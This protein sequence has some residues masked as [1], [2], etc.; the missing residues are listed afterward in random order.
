VSSITEPR[1]AREII[2]S[3]VNPPPEII[4]ENSTKKNKND[5]VEI[6]KDVSEK[7]FELLESLFNS[8]KGIAAIAKLGRSGESLMDAWNKYDQSLLQVPPTGSANSASVASALP[9]VTDANLNAGFKASLKTLSIASGVLSGISSI[10]SIPERRTHIIKIIDVIKEVR[11]GEFKSL[12]LSFF[13]DEFAFWFK[14][15]ANDIEFIR[16]LES[17]HFYSLGDVSSKLATLKNFSDGISSLLSIWLNG[18]KIHYALLKKASSKIS[19]AKWE[20]R[21]KDINSWKPENIKKHAD[22]MILKTHLAFVDKYITVAK[23]K[24]RKEAD[25]KPLID[26]REKILQCLFAHKVDK[27]CYMNWMAKVERKI[28]AS[29]LP[30]NSRE[31]VLDILHQLNE[32]PKVRSEVDL[33]KITGYLKGYVE[34]QHIAVVINILKSEDLYKGF[35][36]DGLSS[37]RTKLWNTRLTPASRQ[38]VLNILNNHSLPLK[39]KQFAL[40][41]LSSTGFG[42]YNQ[43]GDPNI[44]KL[45]ANTS[46]LFKFGPTDAVDYGNSLHNAKEAEKRWQSLGSYPNQINPINPI[47]RQDNEGAFLNLREYV[48]KKFEH[49]KDIKSNQKKIVTRSLVSIAFSVGIIALVTL[50][51]ALQFS[52]PGSLPT[53]IVTYRPLIFAGLGITVSTIGLIKFGVDELVKVK[54]DKKPV[55]N[56]KFTKYFSQEDIQEDI[57]RRSWA[58]INPNPYHEKFQ[59]QSRKGK[60]VGDLSQECIQKRNLEAIT[61]NLSLIE[62]N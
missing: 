50:T 11:K 24:N 10:V 16:F 20:G 7:I 57:R 38:V 53:F 6:V 48:K 61:P 40:Q 27:I 8:Q 39:D 9:S 13:L 44:Y 47:D 45:D 17:H 22:K 12:T 15:L 46:K 4:G 23:N 41:R 58:V 36:E 2:T 29:H 54:E 42:L 18:I 37:I 34:D 31:V 43:A 19:A 52:A 35:N 5:F 3:W 56:E 14:Q 1:N 62:V 26:Q 30:V 51:V 28:W 49:F 60:P 32:N 25:I 33:D 55:L 21:V 59:P